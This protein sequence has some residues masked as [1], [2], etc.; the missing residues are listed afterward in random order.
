MHLSR[1]EQ[2]IGNQIGLTTSASSTCLPSAIGDRSNT[3][4][5]TRFTLVLPSDFHPY[6]C[7]SPL[8]F[9]DPKIY[10]NLKTN[11]EPT[12][13]EGWLHPCPDLTFTLGPPCFDFKM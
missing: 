13:G 8:M 11:Q 4:T 7:S 12:S 2:L 5:V 10:E 1:K 6:P 9:P 3:D